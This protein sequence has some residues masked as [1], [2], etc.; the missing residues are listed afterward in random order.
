MRDLVAQI[1]FD[2]LLNLIFIERIDDDRSRLLLSR[3]NAL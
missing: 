2:L 1:V 3:R